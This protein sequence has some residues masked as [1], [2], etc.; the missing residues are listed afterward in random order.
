LYSE[1]VA[2]QVIT[3]LRAGKFGDEAGELL[4]DVS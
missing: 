1:T 2:M 3:F 4:F